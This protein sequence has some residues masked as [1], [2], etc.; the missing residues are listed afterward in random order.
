MTKLRVLIVDDAVVVRRLLADALGGDSALEVAGTAANGRIALA[1][2]AQLNPDLVLLDVE[3]PE[4]DGLATLAALRKT[5]PKLPVV[6]FS[7]FTR[8]G[9]AATID[10]LTLG[11]T[12]YV[13][14]PESGA[15]AAETLR[16]VREQLIPKIKQCCAPP[17][18]ASLSGAPARP[19]AR[20]ELFRPQ[21]PLE[22]VALGASTGGPN[23]LT[24]LLATLPPDFPVPVLIV[25]HMPPVFT[26]LLAERLTTQTSL[27]VHEGESGMEPR[28]GYAW[29]APGDFHMALTRDSLGGVRL[30]LHQ[31]APE[32]S[33]RPAADVLFR[34]VADHYG[35]AALAVVLTGMG[36]DGLRGCE[37]IRAAGGQVLVQDEASSVV[38]GMPGFVARAGLA[39]GVLPLEQLGPEIIRRVRKGRTLSAVGVRVRDP[40]STPPREPCH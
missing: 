9:A 12:D 1:K 3:M 23:A 15:G 30:R 13:T 14:M 33:C 8:R 16:C 17:V 6:M 19:V 34:A 4:M 7:R 40:E 27:R 39:D 37:R 21:P 24:A 10:A 32:N 5:H 35:P 2:L 31:A 22:V 26:R 36:Q 38:W 20:P 29:L 25:Q 28:P 11:A 18:P